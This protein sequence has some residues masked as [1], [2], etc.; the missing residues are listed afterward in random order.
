MRGFLVA[1]LL[2]IIIAIGHISS[3]SDVTSSVEHSNR[4]A[5]LDDVEKTNSAIISSEKITMES[6]TFLRTLTL[7]RQKALAGGVSG[8]VAGVIQVLTLMW[9]RTT[10][11]YQYRYGLSMTTAIRELYRQG[12][13]NRFYRGLPYAIIQG[14]LARFG[15][16]AANDASIVF[17]AYLTGQPESTSRGLLSTALGGVLAGNSM[18]TLYISYCFT[19]KNHI[20]FASCCTMNLLTVSFIV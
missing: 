12:G 13:I 15:G 4:L 14:P 19:I 18:S 6:K 2:V 16:I 5:I 7:A 11:N 9:L 10:V 3:I 17:A 1:R 20:H 8:F